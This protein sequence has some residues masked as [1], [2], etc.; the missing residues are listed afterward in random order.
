MEVLFLPHAPYSGSSVYVVNVIDRASW[1]L[2]L[3]PFLVGIFY[4]IYGC[5]LLNGNTEPDRPHS[6]ATQLCCSRRPLNDD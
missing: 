6:A 3:P 4:L 5:I 2:V 1:A